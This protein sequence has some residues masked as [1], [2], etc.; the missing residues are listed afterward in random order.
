MIG[1]DQ[2]VFESVRAYFEL[3]GKQLYYCGGAG[4]GLQAKLTQ[5]L[6]LSNTLAAFNEG[7][8]L[9]TKAGIDPQLMLEILNNSTARS[10]VVAFKAPYVFKRD[11]STNFS[12]KW[13]HKDIGL[14]ME[15]GKELNVPLPVTAVTQ[16][17][18]L[19]AI[20][21]GYGEDDFCSAIKV[22]EDWAGVE[23]RGSQKK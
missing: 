1:G 17:M 21:S 4:M 14:M 8:V 10:G 22:L 18:F 23:V 13:M 20:A 12:V 11:F 5:N 3:M 2:Q 7:I 9:S 6:I 19:A 15:S 16:Q